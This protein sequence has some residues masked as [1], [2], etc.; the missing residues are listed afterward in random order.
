VG[1]DIRNAFR[2]NGAQSFEEL[3][4][5]LGSLE[6]QLATL[7]EEKERGGQGG[8]S[9]TAPAG[10]DEVI[11]ELYEQKARA[12]AATLVD[13]QA[14]IDS[15]EAQL[16][17]LYADREQ[18]TTLASAL[19]G[20][21]AQLAA[22][23]QER[24]EAGGAGVDELRAVCEGLDA[25]LRALYDER[26][27]A[28]GRSTDELLGIIDGLEAQLHALYRE[29]EEQQITTELG[30]SGVL[31]LVETVRNF[32]E[33]LASL[34][35]ERAAMRHAP[36]EADAMVD[37]LEAQV[38]ALLEERNELQAALDTSAKELAAVRAKARDVVSALLDRTL[39]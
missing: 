7:Y 20:L 25:Q 16:A 31:A 35:A 27:A 12:S 4:E 32:E 8:W 22:L 39:A 24:E 26:S 15:L 36:D 14:T 33:Q 11:I 5:M 10:G 18:D 6:A 1:I 23:Y 28:G 19:E 2:A 37:S 30:A 17:S 38:A 21:E 13:L 9:P 3:H 34:Y 29:R